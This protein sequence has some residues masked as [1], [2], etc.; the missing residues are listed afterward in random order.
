VNT[1]SS[2]CQEWTA[3]PSAWGKGAAS[4]TGEEVGGLEGEGAGTVHGWSFRWWWIVRG[5]SNDSWMKVM[6]ITTSNSPHL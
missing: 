3:A 6:R 5:F 4:M 2:Y 1:S